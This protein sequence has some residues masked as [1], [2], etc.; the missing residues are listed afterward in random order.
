MKVAIIQNYVRPYC[1]GGAEINVENFARHLAEKGIPTILIT[2]GKNLK[3][4]VLSPQRHLKLYRFYPLNLY[5]NYPPNVQ[6]NKIIK[7]LW[8]VLNLWNPFVYLNVRAILKREKISR[9]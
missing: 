1:V 6:R 3:A 8:W 7:V 2:S 5:F 9:K 4:E